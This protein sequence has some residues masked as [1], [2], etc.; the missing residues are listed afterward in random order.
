MAQQAKRPRTAEL[1][2]PLRLTKGEVL[3]INRRRA[4]Q[5]Q[6]QAANS[7][8]LSLHDYKLMEYDIG[9]NFP[10]IKIPRKI[11]PHEEC[12]IYRRRADESQKKI[13]KAIG[14]SRYWF[15]LQETGKIPC[16]K[17][18]KYWLTRTE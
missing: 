9:E 7:L 11:F 17:L 13:A 4:K 6:T 5:N 1:Y 8:G 10:V 2:S 16:D 12:Y 18:L 14:V 3:A 15:M